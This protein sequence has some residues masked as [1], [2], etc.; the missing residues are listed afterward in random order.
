MIFIN[1]ALLLKK[2]FLN[3]KPF[4]VDLHRCLWQT[5]NSGGFYFI[6]FKLARQKQKEG[7]TLPAPLPGHQPFLVVIIPTCNGA[8]TRMLMV[9]L[10]NRL[11]SFLVPWIV[12]LGKISK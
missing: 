1:N 7:K 5:S 9:Y 10:P 6:L 8:D 4:H 11:W 2:K 3:L 12:P